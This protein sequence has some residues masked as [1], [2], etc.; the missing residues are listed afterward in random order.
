LQRGY[1]REEMRP[2]TSIVRTFARRQARS[3]LGQI[4]VSIM[5]NSCGRTMRNAPTMNPRSNGKKKH[6]TPR[7]W[8]WHLLAGHRGR[9]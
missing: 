2:L 9:R 1:D 4:S 6:H 8:L 5:M 3:R 7:T